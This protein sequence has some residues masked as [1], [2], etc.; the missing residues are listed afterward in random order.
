MSAS[1]AGR[2]GVWGASGSG[3]SSYVK[4]R[5]ASARRVVILDPLQEYPGFKH[6]HSVDDVRQAMRADWSGFRVALVPRAGQEAKTLSALSRLL[7]RAQAPYRGKKRGKLLTLVVEEMNTCFPVAGGAAK[8]PGFA[9]ICSRGR[10]SWIEA[11]G[12]SQRIAEVDTRFRGNCTETVVFRQKGPRDRKAAA[13]ELGC[14][15][16]DLPNENLSYVIEKAG[17]ISRG[18]VTFGKPANDNRAP[19]SNTNRE[20]IRKGNRKK[21]KFPT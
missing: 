18:Q 8:C 15:P 10:H 11:V 20:P 7:I 19:A 17:G 4:Q 5:I 13:D 3:K 2:V 1:N 12:V 6:V 9:E 21:P 16:S 14:R